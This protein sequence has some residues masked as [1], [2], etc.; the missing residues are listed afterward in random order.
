MLPTRARP[1]K[2]F[3]PESSRVVLAPAVQLS[4]DVVDRLLDLSEDLGEDAGNAL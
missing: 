3:V 2:S 1:L 4:I